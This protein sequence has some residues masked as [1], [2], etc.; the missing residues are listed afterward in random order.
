MGH[1]FE[2]ESEILIFNNI[3]KNLDNVME[4]FFRFSSHCL[5][6]KLILLFYFFI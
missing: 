3:F 6:L 4:K 5:I 1:A 2:N